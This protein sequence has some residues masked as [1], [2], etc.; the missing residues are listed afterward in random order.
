MKL[1]LFSDP[2]YSS[3]S[4]TCGVR[5]NSRSLDKIRRAYEFFKEQKCDSVI[6]L[7]DLIDKEE[8]VDAVREN[9]QSIATVVRDSG[10]PT[11]CLLGNHDAFSLG[12]DEFY[13]VLSDCVPRDA[14][15]DGKHLIF[16]D[17]CY[18]KSGKPYERGDD[19]WTDTFYPHEQHLRDTLCSAHGDVYL[20]IH[21]N[22]D[23][24][25]DGDHR[26][27]NADAL[28]ELINQS[29]RVKA[30]FQGHFHAGK[31]SQYCGV[32]YITLPAMCQ[33]EDACYVFEI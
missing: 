20:F 24:A 22:I 30:V 4:V 14:Q 9:L 2:H 13:S 26:L 10:I 18:F 31:T 21:Q 15:I 29:G 23:P 16:L 3:K 25:I 12:R 1:G 19:D 5:Y 33:N 27:H 7:G 11:A 17:A 6:C 28:F 8:T 32:R